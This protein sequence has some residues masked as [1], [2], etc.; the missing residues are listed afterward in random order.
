MFSLQV[1]SPLCSFPME[2]HMPMHKGLTF[3]I[4]VPNTN[5]SKQCSFLPGGN[6]YGLGNVLCICNLLKV[7]TAL[8]NSYLHSRQL[9]YF[10][11][12]AFFHRSVKII[13]S[14]INVSIILQEMY[15]NK[16]VHKCIILFYTKAPK[17]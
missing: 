1:D 2:L 4:E 9:L 11:L 6:V 12:K 10:L 3:V 14:V 5:I 15:Y 17:C 7:N 16:C 13:C 8:E